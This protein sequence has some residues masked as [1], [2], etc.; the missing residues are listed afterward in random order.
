MDEWR[1][2]SASAH[3][4]ERLVPWEDSRR[5]RNR[6]PEL[7][8][9]RL[10]ADSVCLVLETC[11]GVSPFLDVSRRYVVL[12][13]WTDAL[14]FL[15]VRDIPDSL[16]WLNRSV[17][18]MSSPHGPYRREPRA[19]E[20]AGP[21]VQLD[22]E[23]W[24]ALSGEGDDEVLRERIRGHY[25]QLLSRGDR[26]RRIVAWGTV[27]EVFAAPGVYGRLRAAVS[28]DEADGEVGQCA[29][30]KFCV[31]QA[32]F[33]AVELW[34]EGALEF[35][36]RDGSVGAFPDSAT[37]EEPSDATQFLRTGPKLTL[38]H[39]RVLTA[40]GRLDQAWRMVRAE[41]L[42]PGSSDRL[43]PVAISLAR[44]IAEKYGEREA[45]ERWLALELAYQREPV[46]E[47]SNQEEGAHR[48]VGRIPGSCPIPRP[49]G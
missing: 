29:W 5:S 45:Q 37:D 48:E 8:P 46:R 3:V 49:R 36:A 26:S 44:L 28:A 19:E 42:E 15:L 21:A 18:G 35:F 13:D 41:L 12:R 22:Q 43:W 30:L 34:I 23:L 16:G 14:A 24:E 39:V 47:P 38:A 11:D 31:D 9:S 27:S 10:Q 33:E 6:S 20:A 2:W 7:D 32:W 40:A 17:E 25:G 4:M 1:S